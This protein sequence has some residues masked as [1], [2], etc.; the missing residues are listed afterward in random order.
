[1]C[2]LGH[3]LSDYNEV[4]LN[5]LSDELEGYIG[6]DTTKCHNTAVLVLYMLLGK[7][8]LSTTTWC[9]TDTVRDRVTNGSQP[10]DNYGIAKRLVRDVLSAKDRYKRTV[11]YVMLTDGDLKRGKSTSFFPGHV[12]VLERLEDGS[13]NV[14]QSYIKAYNLRKLVARGHLHR[15]RKYM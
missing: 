6:N 4:I 14:Y 11:F 1:M 9:D 3:I 10:A 2:E 12:F 13:F 15:S 7:S 5:V 8:A